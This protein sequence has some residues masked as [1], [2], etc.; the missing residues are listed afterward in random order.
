MNVRKSFALLALLSSTFTV[1]QSA[2][3]PESKQSVVKATEVMVL[4]TPHL[5]EKGGV[6]QVAL[7][8]M[9]QRLQAFKPD[10]IAVECIQPEVLA[11]MEFRGG[12]YAE[13]ADMFAGPW[14]KAGKLVQSQMKLTRAG[15]QD[16]AEKLLRLGAPATASARRHLAALLLAAYDYDSALLQWSYLPDTERHV[17]ED[18]SAEVVTN[19]DNGL[20]RTSEDVQLAMEAARRLG[21]Q[22]IFAIDDQTDAIVFKRLDETFPG[23]LEKL[24][25]HPES[26]RQREAAIY[27][28]S[29][30]LLEQGKHNGE[31]L[32]REYEYLNSPEY[33][34]KDVDLQ[35]GRYLRTH[36]ESGA[37]RGRLAQWETRNLLIAS[38]IR[39]LS[40]LHPGKRILV[41]IG[42]AH[43]PFLDRYLEQ[44]MDIKLAQ[45]APKQ[46]HPGGATANFF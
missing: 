45:F 13:I 24:Q 15:A 33:S 3:K 12:F 42:A 29:G 10:A 34:E 20:K 2:P 40:A 26:K 17:D 37:D 32:V 41:L 30:A 8:P 25:Q 44:M 46:A 14:L 4:G 16:A 9:R 27:A 36:L 6:D 35:W 38:H 11:D 31:A 7:E 21:L 19:L 43:K 1:A 18:L 28:E 5:R 39:E 22:Q 23:E